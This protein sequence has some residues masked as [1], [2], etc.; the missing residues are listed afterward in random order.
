[1]VSLSFMLNII[2]KRVKGKKIVV[3]KL[4]FMGV[5]DKN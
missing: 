2:K 3:K 5:N 4:D 1:M